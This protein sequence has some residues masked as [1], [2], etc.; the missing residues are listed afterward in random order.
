MKISDIDP[1]I[2]IDNWANIWRGLKEKKSKIFETIYIKKGGDVVDVSI[3]INHIY[4]DGKEI[5]FVIARDIREDRAKRELYLHTQKMS[6][7]YLEVA[8]TIFIVLNRK[9]IVTL[10]N[11]RTSEI[12][13][14]PKSSIIGE[15]WFKKFVPH[16]DFEK[17]KFSFIDSLRRARFSDDKLEFRVID[18]FGNKKII[19]WS[20][21][22]IRDENDRVTGV[23]LSGNDITDK[24]E[25]EE[26][27]RYSERRYRSLFRNSKAIMLLINP[28]S[29]EIIDVNREAEIF[30]EYT[31]QQFKSMNIEDLNTLSSYEIELEMNRAKEENR[32]HF[33][34]KHRKASGEIRDVEVH[35]GP[36]EYENERMLYSIVHDITARL[37]AEREVEEYKR[38]LERLN[39]DLQQRVNNEVLKRVDRE[40]E[41]ST[42]F[43]NAGA[44]FSIMKEG[45]FTDCN[46][47]TLKL[48]KMEK[49]SQFIGKTPLQLSPKFQPNGKSSKELLAE[50]CKRI[51]EKHEKQEFEWVHLRSDNSEILLRVKL[52]PIKVNNEIFVYTIWH[53]ITEQR[54]IEKRQ[55]EQEQILIH[56]S[57]LASMGEMIGAIAHQ[58][59]QP[60]NSLAISLENLQDFYDANGEITED[61]LEQTLQKSVAKIKFMSKTIDDFRNFF[62]ADKS[63]EYFRIRE[64]IENSCSIFGAQFEYYNIKTEIFGDDF[65]ILGL[66]GEFQQVIVNLLSNSFDAIKSFKKNRSGLI[67]IILNSFERSLTI[68]DNGG[69][70]KPEILE[71]IFE[72]Y[73]TTKEEG[74]GSGIG[75]YM[76]KVIIENMKGNIIAINSDTGL[77]IKMEFSSG[78]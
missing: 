78:K 8:R 3:N 68:S 66:K 14:L 71:R 73:F 15:N 18:G 77:N 16:E 12:L 35:S 65:S 32:N 61:F 53:D 69:G 67:R 76:S 27:L 50:R 38:D 48:L 56:Q 42:L 21:S 33:R 20:Y 26:K 5:E 19:A 49:K 40:I 25:I 59:R 58:W 75:L 29:G 52:T 6:E 63:L 4:Y 54:E 74:K 36:I 39:R 43:E 17:V 1:S 7:R 47:E 64:A 23:I 60:L 31:N 34:F 24:K 70:V 46:D 45:I 2:N 41:Y 11:G 10:A 57:K 9:G 28:K 22:C 44:S 62:K 13:S 51:F 55:I 37:K 72:P 30:Y